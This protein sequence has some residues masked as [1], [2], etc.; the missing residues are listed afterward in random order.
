MS[1]WSASD[2]DFADNGDY[3]F[4]VYP[5]LTLTVLTPEISTRSG[6]P[7]V[8]KTVSRSSAASKTKAFF[9]ELI[10]LPSARDAEAV[11]QGRRRSRIIY[12]RDFPTLAASSSSW[13]PQLVAAVR[14]RRQGPIPRPSS[15]VNSS[16]TI[17]FG[18]TPPIV[19][20]SSPPQGGSQ[21]L[22]SLVNTQQ[23]TIMNSSSKP[24]KND[25]GEDEHAE[26]ARERRLRERLRKWERDEHALY[27][28]IPRLSSLGDSSKPASDGSS[29][30]SFNNPI[31]GDS[32][33]P[34]VIA[35]A[36]Q[37]I[38]SQG[39]NSSDKPPFFRMSTL[40]PMIRDT[41]RESDCRVSRRREINMLTMRMSVG[42]IGG[43]LEGDPTIHS[44]TNGHDHPAGVT[45]E[46]TEEMQSKLKMMLDEW[47]Q[48]V[49]IWS[50]VKE[51]ADRAIGNVVATNP[52][53]VISTPT[54][55]GEPTPVPWSAIVSAW[56]ERRSSRDVRK[57]WLHESGVKTTKDIFDEGRSKEATGPEQDEVI[58]RVKED[59]DLS[60]HENRLLRCIVDAGEIRIFLRFAL[61]YIQP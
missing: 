23:T 61:P 35:N 2:E 16:V 28:E 43:R 12:V 29:P 58:R 19:Q 4:S 27:D 60:S 6:R 56:H 49:E 7:T 44:V 52:I 55:P 38:S 37:R 41:K 50:S 30:I 57:T 53:E 9:D 17:V 33:L 22:L 5:K 54:F 25:Y 46:K 26:K 20:P 24:S 32:P 47:G 8:L 13:Y 14:Q 51:I 48:Q 34:S 40:V 21:N 1:S 15:P 39:G 3:G 42:A 36:L 59:S 45:D 10:N 18:I 31:M 11:Q